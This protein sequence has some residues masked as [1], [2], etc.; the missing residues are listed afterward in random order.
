MENSEEPLHAAKR[1]LK[2][3]LGISAEEWIDLGVVNP[4]T[5]TVHSPAYLFLAK[6]LKF[7]KASPDATE[8]IEMKR[9]KIEDA[10]NL[11]LESKIIHG[12]TSVLILKA[13]S[14]LKL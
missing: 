6:K 4:F 9:M 10:V 13:K 14:Y 12:P 5:S 8:M 2:E 7:S 3:E 11:V 1:E